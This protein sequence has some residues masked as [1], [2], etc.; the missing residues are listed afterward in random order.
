MRWPLLSIALLWLQTNS[1]AQNPAAVTIANYTT[2]Q[3]RLLAVSTAQFINKITL[4][5]LDKDSVQVLACH[6]T[7]MPFLLPYSEDFDRNVSGG[8]SLINDGRI[9]AAKEL[10][11]SLQSEQQLQLLLELGIYYLHQPGTHEKDLDSADLYITKAAALS[12]SNSYRR[13][14][15]ECRLLLGQL[16]AQKG[17]AAKSKAIFMQEAASGQNEGDPAT[18]ARAYQYLGELFPGTDSTIKAYYQSALGLRRKIHQKEKEIELLWLV[19]ICDRNADA[20]VLENDL[21]QM[22]TLM[23][24]TG[25]KHVLYAENFLS[26]AYGRQGKYF[27]ALSHA[28]AALDNVRWSGIDEMAASIYISFGAFY[29]SIGKNDEALVWYNKGLEKRT[30]ETHLFWYRSFIYAATLLMNTRPSASLALIDTITSQFPPNSVWEKMELLSIKGGCYQNL[31]Q[32]SLADKNY[33]SILRLSNEHPSEDSYGEF[34][35]SYL[36]SANFYVS[37]PDVNKARLF[38]KKAEANPEKNIDIDASRYALLY[39][40]DSLEGNYR[41]AMQEH[42]KFKLYDDSLK[43]FDQRKQMDELSVKYS[44]EKKDQDIK[45]LKQHDIVQQEELKQNRLTRNIMIAGS[46]MMSIIIILLFSQFRLKQR[47]NKEMSKTNL[48][49][50]KLLNEKEWLIKEVHHRVKNNLQTIIS[51]LESQAAYLENDALKAIAISQNRIYTMS[52][53]HQKLYQ[54]EDIQTIDMSDYIP[55]LIK[56]LKDSFDNSHKIDFKLTIDP[57]HLDTSIAIPVALIINE[58]LTNSIKY[59]FPGNRQ[60]EIIVSLCKDGD[61]VELKLADN[62]IGLDITSINANPVS[63]GHQLIKGLTKEIHGDIR[64]KSDHGLTITVLFKETPLEYANIL[65]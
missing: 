56:Y 2:A 36:L 34:E 42:I 18:A 29:E 37:L 14:E 3:K 28:T 52:L 9:T 8:E 57:V 48:A 11:T 31:N 39:K 49:L 60:G 6:I 32:P 44:A 50:K 64:F 22:I 16:Y 10:L 30:K 5:H 46:V 33:M 24:A 13:W 51:L 27:D 12:R 65:E 1:P 17:N 43:S 41:S 4:N 47:T 40:I 53:I 58:A 26:V 54:S 20:H 21:H 7:G 62:G 23:Q 63:L 61:S 35:F 38:L 25:Y 19:S 59:A 55:E 15:H 45:L